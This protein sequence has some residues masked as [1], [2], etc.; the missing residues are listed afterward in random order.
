MAGPGTVPAARFSPRISLTSGGHGLLLRGIA[1]G[2]R[3]VPVSDAPGAAVADFTFQERQVLAMQRRTAVRYRCAVGT[4]GRLVFADGRDSRE[5]WVCN[6]SESGIGLN[7]PGDPLEPG[8]PVTVRL[9]G[10]TPD[11]AVTLAA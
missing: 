5:V 10:R 9:H 4:A 2:L 3:G 7:L 1:P 11:S 8:T 6:L